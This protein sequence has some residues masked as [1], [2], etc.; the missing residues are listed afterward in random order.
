MCVLRGLITFNLESEVVINERFFERM[1]NL[2]LL[3]KCV[4]DYWI[5]VGGRR[6]A[7]NFYLNE[8]GAGVSLTLFTIHS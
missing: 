8:S 1:K 4:R 7:V 2:I 3:S 5:G 6:G